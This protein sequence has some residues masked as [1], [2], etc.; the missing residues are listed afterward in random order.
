MKLTM[1]VIPGLDSHQADFAQR[2]LP[3]VDRDATIFDTSKLMRTT[4][5]R[6]VLVMGQS[7][8]MRLPLGVISA[9]EIVTRVIA[10]EL[11][12]AAPIY[13]SAAHLDREMEMDIYLHYGRPGYWAAELKREAAKVQRVL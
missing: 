6:E 8:G 3:I 2:E 11:N 9:T 10:A 13:D 4:G 12:P 5:A 7:D 1:S